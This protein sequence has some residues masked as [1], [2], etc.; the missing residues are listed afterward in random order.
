M[1]ETKWDHEQAIAVRFL[2]LLGEPQPKLSRPSGP[3]PDVLWHAPEGL[4]GLELT[5]LL[6]DQALVERENLRESILA[7]ARSD[8]A[9]P[10]DDV[11]VWVHWHD[12]SPEPGA[13]LTELALDLLSAVRAN[14]PPPGGRIV[15]GTEY[16]FTR[17]FVHPVYDRIAIDRT[18]THGGIFFTTQYSD[19]LQVLTPEH[20]DSRI[21]R[22]S[23]RNRAGMQ[24]LHQHWLIIYGEFGPLSSYLELAPGAVQ[25][26]YRSAFDR[27]Y[28]AFLGEGK[29]WRLQT[30]PLALGA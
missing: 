14:L 7:R 2:A 27:L 13:S 19:W 25:S 23:R 20:L 10:I 21:T 11:Y 29:V 3:H 12:G 1:S 15:L 5:R 6:S 22:K 18:A 8:P 4:V 9:L 16:D 28:L 30:V 26:T 24:P 17:E